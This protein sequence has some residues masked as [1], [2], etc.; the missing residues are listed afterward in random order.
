MSASDST[1][2]PVA[3]RRSQRDWSQAEL[4]R[5]SNVPRTTVSAIEGDRLTPAVTT[6]L[7]L[8]RAL[9]CSVE[10]LFGGGAQTLP[11]GPAWAWKPAVEPCRYWE[12]EVGGRRWLYPVENLALN[13]I[14]H[15]GVWRGESGHDVRAGAAEATLVLACCDPAAGLLAAE[16]ARAGG[17][18][19][20]VLQ[21]GGGEAIALLKGGLVHV[22][23]LH[24][25]TPRQ[26]KRNAETVRAELGE[27]FRLVRVADWQE[28]LALGA[29]RRS[30]SPVSAARRV[31]RWALREEGSAAREC[32]DE[33]CADASGRTVHSH[34]AVAEAVRGG[35][36]E[37]GVCVQLSAAEAGLNFLPVRA[38]ALDLC[39]AAKLQHDPRIQSLL[40]LLRSRS[41]R[42]FIGELPGYDTRHTGELL[43]V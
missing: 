15:D 16:Y 2:H 26:P 12:A 6:A 40:R 11:D 36:A 41:Y 39:F 32:L 19:L 5:R 20:I 27:G 3:R 8:A 25:S 28:G 21:R 9:E 42:Q 37:A 38:E 35:W 30:R 4:A 7:A 43:S 10:E 24:R 1:L 17:F 31:H 33:L 23:G 18:R 14:P 13:V 29:D 34:A 22:A